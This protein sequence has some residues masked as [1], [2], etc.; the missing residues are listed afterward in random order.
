VE[1]DGAEGL[2]LSKDGEIIIQTGLGGLKLSKPIAWQEKDGKKLPVEVS[3]KLIGKNRYSFEVAKADP[4]LPIVI[5]P[6]LQATYLGGGAEDRATAIAI[7]SE[8]GEV[9]V[10]GYTSSFNFPGTSGGAQESCN[11]CS[12]GFYFIPPR[13]DAFVVRLN[14]ELT[15]IL[16][17]TYLGGR[18]SD[19]VYAIAI[20]PIT[21]DVYVA[22]ETESSD[23]P[24]TAGGAQERCNACRPRINTLPPNYDGFVARLN[25]DLTQLLQS[26]YL[27]GRNSDRINAIAIHPQT[28]EVYVAGETGSTDFPNT[29]GGAQENYRNAFVSRLSAD[30][31]RISQ[32][33]YLGGS[34]YGS[35][36]ALAIHPTTGEVYVAGE[37]EASDFP[38]TS[39]SAQPTLGG[40]FDAFVVRLRPDLQTGALLKA[41][42]LGGSGS[43]EAK[44]IAIHPATGDVY[45]VGTTSSTDF[46]H[47]SGSAQPSFSG[48]EYDT[49]V[50]RLNSSLTQILQSTYLGG[51]HRDYPKALAFHPTTGDIY[52]VGGTMSTDFPATAG[53][54]QASKGGLW[55]AFVSRLNKELTQVVQ[56][57]YLGG[58]WGDSANAITIHPKTGEIYVA[59]YTS[60][61]DFPRTVG[62]AQESRGDSRWNDA[63]VA[64]ITA[65]LRAGK[66]LAINP[67]P[68]NGYVKSTPNGIYC[69]YAGW[70][71]PKNACS[72]DF[73]GTITLTAVPDT[74]YRFTG[75]GGDCAGCGTNSTCTINMD[76]DKSCFA[77]FA[78]SGIPGGGIGGGIG[79]SPGGSFGGG[80]GGGGGC[81]MTGSSASPWNILVW[82]SVPFFVLAR[83][84]RR[85]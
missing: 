15:Q 12:P 67:R 23:F 68:E 74:N 75:W 54:V 84:V 44:A 35:V 7:N 25:S 29:S 66:T 49:F 4:S 10:A 82:L 33:T 17:A 63:F 37:T 47:T 58:I 21:G 36:H 6:I 83:R 78:F 22:G 71:G 51:S 45:V 2:K 9:Y 39:G 40:R 70:I 60:S 55:D 69:G 31:T 64:R 61:P 38:G 41:T 85:K 19:Y 8:T 48:G 3:Y 46:P 56:S 11:N 30:L 27:G 42:Y 28:G 52:V 13:Y 73:V 1:V 14:K 65:D 80:G 79:G 81:S 43:D 16:Q 18:N 77:N 50:A 24:N 53:G 76:A 32:S 62:G 72:A 26:T 34:G 59:G 20:H 57:T 5:D